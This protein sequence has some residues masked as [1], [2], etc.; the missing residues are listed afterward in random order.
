MEDVNRFIIDAGGIPTLPW[1]DGTSEGERQ[2][3]RL[4][5]VVMQSGNAAI[6]IVPERNITSNE[7]LGNLYNIVGLAE[8]LQLPIIVGTEMN[9]PGQKFVD[10]FK[11]KELL[12]LL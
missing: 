9:S 4:L 11:S 2:L 3:E 7:R 5:E 6:N 1:L 10:D 8:K 12:R